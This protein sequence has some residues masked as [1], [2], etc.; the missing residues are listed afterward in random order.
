V[1]TNPTAGAGGLLV[2]RGTIVNCVIWGNS[3]PQLRD[4]S[5]PTY[6]CVQGIGGGEGNIDADPRFIDPDGPDDKPDT[7]EDN[8]FHLTPASACIDTALND[9]WMSNAA[10]LDG[11]PRIWRGLF[12]W[13]VDMGAYEYESSQFKCIEIA[14]FCLPPPGEC[15]V[16]ITWNSRPGDSYTVM[17][18]SQLGPE[19]WI[20]EDTVQSAGELTAWIDSQTVYAHK[21]YRVRID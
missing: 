10:D 16:A 15:G 2:C 12:A 21:F 13:T 17:S 9:D 11:N 6:C 7:Y 18:C 19:E 3:D 4:C 20:E 1:S 5:F 14:V 8:D